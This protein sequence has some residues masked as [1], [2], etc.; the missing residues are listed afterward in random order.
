MTCP[1]VVAAVW[2]LGSAAD[3]LILTCSWDDLKGTFKHCSLLKIIRHRPHTGT[4]GKEKSLTET[5][6]QQSV[7]DHLCGV[8]GSLLPFAMGLLNEWAQGLSGQPAII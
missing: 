2:A 3:I 7:L 4:Y 5:L 1:G 8:C 6:E